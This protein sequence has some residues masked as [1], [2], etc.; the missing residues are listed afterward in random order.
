MAPVPTVRR[1]IMPINSAL[2]ASA[3]FIA[4]MVCSDVLEL[5]PNTTTPPTMAAMAPI[6]VVGSKLIAPRKYANI[7]IIVARAFSDKPIPG[8]SCAPAPCLSHCRAQL[9]IVRCVHAMP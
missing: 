7:Q 6:R 5:D 1:S 8:F 2:H 9:R 4:A 3:F